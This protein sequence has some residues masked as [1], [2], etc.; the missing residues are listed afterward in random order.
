MIDF[1]S[2]LR[3]TSSYYTRWLN[4]E[5]M[6][7]LISIYYI[8]LYIIY[9]RQVFKPLHTYMHSYTYIYTHTYRQ[10]YEP[11]LAK[12]RHE[13]SPRR[14]RPLSPVHVDIGVVVGGGR[15]LRG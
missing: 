4:Y 7:V 5:G 9:K 10:V 2:S 1:T 6:V 3:S 15:W 14:T 11:L 13:P 12:V 8:Y